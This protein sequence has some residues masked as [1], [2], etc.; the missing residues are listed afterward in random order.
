MSSILAHIVIDLYRLLFARSI[1]CRQNFLK[2]TTSSRSPTIPWMA[3]KRDCIRTRE[4]SHTSVFT[5]PDTRSRLTSME[6]WIMVKRHPSSFRRLCRII[7]YRVLKD[8]MN[9][10]QTSY[11]L[12]S[13][14]WYQL[15]SRLVHVVRWL[16]FHPPFHLVC[17]GIL[18]PAFAFCHPEVATSAQRK[19]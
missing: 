8:D 4:R 12:K 19:Y 13:Q 18:L 6:T 14:G 11:V 5:G 10:S 15:I 9:I 7:V 16:G 3:L 1:A 2:C 17:S